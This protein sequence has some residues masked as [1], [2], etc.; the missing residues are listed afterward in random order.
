MKEHV[1]MTTRTLIAVVA[2]ATVGCTGATDVVPT[3]AE[4]YMVTSHG[5]GPSSAPEQRAK[6]F[7]EA[8]EYCEKAGKKFETI[9][10]ID[11]GPVGDGKTSTAEVHFRCV[12]AAT[13]N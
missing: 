10:V 7:E 11:S 4:T 13:P 9:R 1:R 2:A 12:T 6:A 5:T 3:G 8:R